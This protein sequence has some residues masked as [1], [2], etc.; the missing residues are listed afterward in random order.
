MTRR[1]DRRRARPARA[2]RWRPPP[3]HRPPPAR[4]RRVRARD[5]P[6][7]PRRSGPPISAV[8]PGVR[9]AE[10]G[11]VSAPTGG[12]RHRRRPAARGDASSAIAR[13]ARSGP[14]PRRRR[15]TRSS[16]SASWTSGSAPISSGSRASA[17]RHVAE[18]VPT[19]RRVTGGILGSS[20]LLSAVIDR[21]IGLVRDG[22]GSRGA[23]DPRRTR[24]RPEASAVRRV[25]AGRDGRPDA[26]SDGSPGAS[27]DAAWADALG[28][29][30]FCL[31]D[32]LLLWDRAG[33]RREFEPVG[34]SSARPIRGPAPAAGR[35]RPPFEPRPGPADDRRGT[36]RRRRRD[37][38][39]R[40]R[41]PLGSAGPD[42]GG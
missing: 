4:R 36:Q 8:R 32:F 2:A 22:V 1:G 10:S 28:E 15:W 38:R 19:D 42:R 16:T 41:L 31:D 33:S 40:R 25:H 6:A 11:P 5:A 21:R 26:P 13:S 30:A 37:A 14:G 23:S 20:M 9:R 24:A 29:A 35:L 27:V 12:P 7:G 39:P 17:A 34:A 18:L 3:R